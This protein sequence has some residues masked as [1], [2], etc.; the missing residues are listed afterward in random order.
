ME[1]GITRRTM[2]KIEADVTV[3]IV[4]YNT[5][6]MTARCVE[7]I[8]RQRS[9]KSIKVCVVDNASKD[10]TVELLK[11]SFPTVDVLENGKNEGFA[12]AQNQA[13]RATKSQLIIVLNS[14]VILE[15][16]TVIEKMVESF[17]ATKSRGVRVV[18]PQILSETGL[19]LTSGRRLD[20]TIAAE[21][22]SDVNRIFKLPMWN[23]LSRLARHIPRLGFIHDNFTVPSESVEVGYVDGMCLLTDRET[24]ERIGL[25]DEQLFFDNE[26]IDFGFRLRKAGWTMLFD[27]SVSVVHLGG[28]TRRNV[29]QTVVWSQDSRMRSMAKN[30]SEIF[31]VLR[32]AN[33]ALLYLR[34]SVAK[35]D[36]RVLVEKMIEV[37]QAVRSP[38]AVQDAELVSVS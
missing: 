12:K 37:T 2:K 32:R 22:G 18:G 23:Q 19:V 6:S 36:T 13:A 27:P 4:T 38:E 24:I 20:R 33:L 16:D 28:A 21:I 25:F 31:P 30:R 1:S 34:R 8:L 5:M 10:N 9:S 14:D 3:H 29:S 26:I 35:G 17:N 11:S 15:D 7:S